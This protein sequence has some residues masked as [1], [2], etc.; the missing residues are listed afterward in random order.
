MNNLGPLRATGAHPRLRLRLASL[1]RGSVVRKGQRMA[2]GA[3]RV[4]RQ[5]RH[6]PWRNH[7]RWQA[8]PWQGGREERE[9]QLRLR[10]QGDH[11]G[12]TGRPQRHGALP[13]GAP[14]LQVRLVP[15]QATKIK[16]R[17]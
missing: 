8:D 6:L 1:P 16:L 3:R 17:R 5:G 15:N 10:R 2:P 12:G 14:R 7:R 11:F 13:Q 9:G 4:D